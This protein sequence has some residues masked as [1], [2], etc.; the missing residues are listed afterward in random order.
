MSTYKITIEGYV[1]DL[2]SDSFN[3]RRTLRHFDFLKVG[4]SIVADRTNRLSL[5]LSP[6]NINILQ[7]LDPIK[8]LTT[9]PYRNLSIVIEQSG[10]AKPIVGVCQITSVRDRIF[11]DV[12]SRI[13]SFW[14]ALE[15]LYL[16]DINLF[17]LNGRWRENEH[18]AARANTSGMISAIV[19]QGQL[20]DHTTYVDH[21]NT[22]QIP[23]IY[24]HTVMTQVFALVGYSKAG[25]IFSDTTRY[26]KMAMSLNLK[27]NEVWLNTVIGLRVLTEPVSVFGVNSVVPGLSMDGVSYS[28]SL[29]PT[30]KWTINN[31]TQGCLQVRFGEGTQYDY[32]AKVKFR[33]TCKVTMLAGSVAN[34]TATMLQATI[35]NIASTTVVN[36]D[37]IILE[38]NYVS[39]QNQNAGALSN[40]FKIFLSSSVI[41][42]N[43]S[44]SQGVLEVIPLNTTDTNVVQDG[45]WYWYFNQL[46]PR[47]TLKD[48]IKDFMRMFGLVIREDNNTVTFKTIQEILSDTTPTA[49]E[50]SRENKEIIPTI[51][52]KPEGFGQTNNYYW[53]VQDDEL[54][55][56]DTYGMGKFLLDNLTLPVIQDIYTSLF[57]ASN[58]I[59]ETRITKAAE[60]KIYDQGTS[61]FT[62][63]ASYG[64]RLILLRASDGVN[65]RYVAFTD[66]TNYLIGYFIDKAQTYSLDWQEL[67]TQYYTEYVDM[68]NRYVTVEQQF[69]I[70]NKEMKELDMF[71]L[72]TKDGVTYLL[73]SISDYQSDKF[74]SFKLIKR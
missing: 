74:A 31:P 50:L 16:N 53:T 30:V 32:F 25:N 39:I 51:K 38:S 61:A 6:V 9:R 28:S 62:K 69:L 68:L 73:E 52:Y 57:S 8:A 45:F 49:N 59:T 15:G 29:N 23:F 44:F 64:Y 35:G 22:V 36:G 26:L 65:Y 13:K 33:F 20:V 48:F 63:A 19:N 66:R 2:G 12:Q 4:T 1:M 60:I 56:K 7:M 27:Y 46:L 67:L 41:G 10:G 58:S 24:Y 3:I 37:T 42:S 72:K 14:D 34:I 71:K 21:T 18:D 11:I 70:T 40:D 47:I 54:V 17:S 55:I 43:A 5:P